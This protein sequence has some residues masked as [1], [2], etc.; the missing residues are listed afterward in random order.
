MG[1]TFSDGTA[2]YT[3]RSGTL[4]VNEPPRE[5]GVGLHHAIRV[6]GISDRPQWFPSLGSV[7]ASA[8]RASPHGD[9][10][11]ATTVATWE[12]CRFPPSLSCRQPFVMAT[13]LAGVLVLLST[14]GM[15]FKEGLKV[16]RRED[17]SLL[18]D[19]KQG[20]AQVFVC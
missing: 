15:G 9:S 12:G 17:M 7:V 13:R 5:A 3:L 6:L 8:V 10:G 14:R 1:L 19:F 4:R 16:G 11:K 2:T 18:Q 20:N